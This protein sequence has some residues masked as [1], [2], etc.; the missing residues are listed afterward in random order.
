MNYHLAAG[1]LLSALIGFV[2]GLIGGGGS[3]VTVPVL[4]YI[5][6]VEAHGAIGMSLAVVG[7]T[8]LVGVVAHARRGN[9]DYRTG[10]FFGG[11]GVAGALAGSRLTPL[12]SPQALMIT[13]AALM[14]AVALVML[15]RRRREDEREESGVNFWKAGIAGLSVGVLTGFLGVG[16]GFLIVPALVLFGGLGMKQAVGTSLMVIAINCA[17]GF[18]GHMGHG[19]LP[20]GLTLAV[21][22]IAAA[23]TVGGTVCGQRV[24]AETLS[25][26]FAVFVIVVAI[27]LIIKNV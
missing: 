1:L 8:S 27:F 14:L 9:V 12:L 18:L 20:V 17:A 26:G 23:G 13:F 4:V 7:V 11:A 3:I 24:S 15:L 16:G 10:V 25:R 22:A 5:L 2:L 19:S 6:G 21:T